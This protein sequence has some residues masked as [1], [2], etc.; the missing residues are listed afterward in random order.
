MTLKWS[1]NKCFEIQKWNISPNILYNKRL[2]GNYGLCKIW[3]TYFYV[4]ECF[5][6][7]YIHTYII[8]IY[9][10]VCTMHFSLMLKKVRST[11]SPWIGVP[12]GCERQCRAENQ[13]RVLWK[14]SKR[15]STTQL[16]LQPLNDL[17]NLLFLVFSHS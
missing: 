1:V 16:P 15:S 14:S 3:F 8:H 7:I 6:C 4:Y 10:H 13:T 9:T 11:G 5:T 17:L 12:S 2:T